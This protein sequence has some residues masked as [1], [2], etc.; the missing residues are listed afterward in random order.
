VDSSLT[1]TAAGTPAEPAPAAPAPLFSASV[2]R[3]AAALA[4]IR[5]RI[6]AQHAA[7]SPGIQAC[8]LATDMFDMAIIALWE[9]LVADLGGADRAAVRDRVAVVAHGG[10]GRRQMAPGSDVD[11]MLLHDGSAAARRA[12]SAAAKRLLQDLCDAGFTVGQSVRSLAEAVRL[13]GAD[14]TILSSLLDSRTLAGPAGLVESLA[15]KL[16]KKIARGRRRVATRLL[17]ARGEEADRF[18]RSVALLEPNVKRSRGGL[19]DI[20]LVRWLG[21]VLHDVDTPEELAMAGAISRADAAAIR[22]AEEFLVRVRNDLHLA[23]GKP[24]DDLTRDQ[25]L[26]IAQARGIESCAGL[27]GVERFM[28][29][30]FGHARRVARVVEALE[31]GVRRPARLRSLTSGLFG[32]EVDGLY[33]VGPGGVAALPGRIDRVAGSVRGVIRLVELATLYDLPI[34]ARTW[35]QVRAAAPTLSPAVDSADRDAFLALFAR[36]E[37]L[38]QALRRLHEVGVLE[39]LIPGF[40]HARDLLQFNNYHT[41]TVDEHCIVAVERAV[42]F[43]SDPGWLGATWR[44]LTRKRPL[45]L[46]LLI[47]DLGKGFVEDHSEVGARIARD[48]AARLALPA[49][50]GEIVEFLVLRHLAMAHLAFRRDVGDAGLVVRFA[51]DVG[52]PEVLRM[53]SLLTAADVSAVGPGTWTKWKADLLGDL[54]YRALGHL[55][56][57][58]P[59]VDADRGRRAL[60]PLLAGRDADDPLVRIARR[61]P[62]AVLRDT[63]LPR[64]VEEIGRLSRLPA[65]GVFAAARWQPETG[66]VAVSV[67]TREEVAPGIFHRVTGALAAERLEILA[68]DIHTLDGGLVLDHFTALDPDFAGE[69]PADRLAD[70]AAA[71]REAVKADQPPVFSR[72]WNPFAPRTSPVGM[73]PARIT[74]DTESSAETTILEV[75][76]H[77]SPGL[78]YGIARALF[79]A[80][81]SV[82]SARIGTYL[83]Q[84]VD[85]FHVTDRQGRKV[86]DPAVL[87]AVRA[88]I[89]RVAAPLTGPA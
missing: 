6:A 38:G 60:A 82:R 71:I 89:E 73:L 67:G 44:E 87:A 32:H 57:E 72:V 85:A 56:G 20:Q 68:A 50:E 33:R 62:P 39:M 43:A 65:D 9:A 77:D 81:L 47:H 29:D 52:S 51:R 86:V 58:A 79:D 55:D 21:T 1:G 30:Y 41:F 42:A 84:V 14:A 25:Q 12:A 35:E 45:L 26:R 27:L 17:A 54:H 63:P 15:V 59:S 76:A 70:I 11:L 10:Y 40:S 69:P 31:S 7:G 36:P 4:E 66:T 80:G 18:G 2:A 22:T 61:L 3:A 48:V 34:D 49:D 75:F 23:A 83:D 24:A 5:N 53:L 13:A 74:F 37:G 46:A 88:A 19:R 16:R 28:R 78:L 8:A 64:L